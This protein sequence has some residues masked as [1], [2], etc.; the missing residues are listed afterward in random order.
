MAGI[1][2]IW[3][4]AGRAPFERTVADGGNTFVGGTPRV[5]A[6]TQSFKLSNFQNALLYRGDVFSCCV[7]RVSR[8]DGEL[9]FIVLCAVV[10]W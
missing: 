2:R 4:D 6:L 10:C 8:C 7:I 9:F 3:Y 5:W 1:R